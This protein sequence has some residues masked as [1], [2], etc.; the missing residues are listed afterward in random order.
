MG[1][2]LLLLPVVTVAQ[3]EAL[4]SGPAAGSK[5]GVV[6]C[7]ALTGPLAGQEFDAME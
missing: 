2:L 3:E 7:Y 5:A 6:S 4:I 1:L